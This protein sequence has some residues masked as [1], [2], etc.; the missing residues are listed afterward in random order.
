MLDLM[1]KHARSWFIQVALFAIILVFV[2]WGV[3]TFNEDKRN[4]IAVVNNSPITLSEYREAYDTLLKRYRDIYKDRLSDELIDK[5]NLKK[6]ALENLIDRV[7]LLQEAE[8]LN[9]EVTEEE[10]RES[11]M[12]YPSFQKDG[13][14]DNSKYVRLLR[15]HRMSPEE[16][17]ASQRRDLLIKKVA[18]FIKDNAKVLD[19]EVSDAYIEEN[20]SVDIEFVKVTPSSFFDRVKVSDDDIKD[21]FSKH[22]EKYKIAAKVNVYYLSFNPKNYESKI[23]I[24]ETDINDYYRLNIEGFKVPEKVKVRYILIKTASGDNSE[25]VKK[26]REKAEKVVKEIQKGVKFASLAGKYSDDPSAKKG[27]DLGYI[28]KVRLAGPVGEAISSLK[29]GEVSPIIESPF[30][31]HIVKVEKIQD[32]KTRSLKE[33]K[34]QIL[35]V[36]KRERAQELADEEAED[37]YERIF[38]EDNLKE[39]AASEK[40]D[41]HQTGLFTMGEDLKEIDEDRTFSN[42]AFSLEKGEISEIIKASGVNYILQMFERLAPRIPELDE[43]DK[44]V[45]E[46][47]KKKKGGDMARTKAEKLLEELKTAKERKRLVSKNRLK[48]EETGF[49]KRRGGAIPKVGYSEEINK[50]AFLLTPDNPYANKVFKVN[51]SYFILRLKEKK[52]IDKDKFESEKDRF[53]EALLEQKK[54]EIFRTWLNGLK[55]KAEIEREI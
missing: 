16:F 23:E 43:V 11:I 15:Y 36:L 54:E 1:R 51:D 26:A 17:E 10:L 53:K 27:G 55:E 9:F 29:A 19:K 22:K 25:S 46:D 49:F 50:D 41:I 24:T 2:F 44:N 39:F 52:G 7:L 31:F 18:E 45:R 20:E 35:S 8:G 48:I 42:A 4:R 6:M 3:G 28:E 34:P 40:M 13:N 38:D 37:V 47:V 33:V 14:F 12:N 30:G 32:A 5:L 21:Y